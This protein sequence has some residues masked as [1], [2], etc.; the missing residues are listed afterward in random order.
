MER[1]K[2]SRD[3]A[4]TVVGI[5]GWRFNDSGVLRAERFAV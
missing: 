3:L 4:G 5:L 2:R 1:E